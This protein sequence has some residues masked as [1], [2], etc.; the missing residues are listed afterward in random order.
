MSLKVVLGAF[1]KGYNYNQ[2]HVE[3]TSPTWKNRDWNKSCGGCNFITHNFTLT[4]LC[5]QV[6]QRPRVFGFRQATKR[7]WK[8]IN[9]VRRHLP[10]CS[11][12]MNFT[13]PHNSQ[14]SLNLKVCSGLQRHLLARGLCPDTRK[15]EGKPAHSLEADVRIHFLRGNYRHRPLCPCENTKFWW[16][17]STEP[18]RRQWNVLGSAHC[19]THRCAKGETRWLPFEEKNTFRLSTVSLCH[20]Q[21]HTA[22]YICAQRGWTKSEQERERKQRLMESNGTI[23][24]RSN[25]YTS[26]ALLLWAMIKT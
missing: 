20:S 23:P 22:A 1:L 13:C 24:N 11:W 7:H 12:Q 17:I 18:K 5:S 8:A 19:V 16:P 4:A 6:K 21:S 10:L 26:N 3:C 2:N 15:Q 25:S 14:T 9:R